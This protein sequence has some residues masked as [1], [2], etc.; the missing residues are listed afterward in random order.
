MSEAAEVDPMD[1]IM[2][3]YLQGMGFV[4]AD[5]TNAMQA[6]GTNEIDIVMEYLLMYPSSGD[7]GREFAE[8]FQPP[9]SGEEIGGIP[10]D[11]PSGEEIGGTSLGDLGGIPRSGEEIGIFKCF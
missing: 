1:E 2:Q 8:F 5:I 6:T 4:R 3:S 10:A 11:G 9:G 7:V